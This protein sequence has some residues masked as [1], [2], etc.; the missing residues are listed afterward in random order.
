MMLDVTYSSQ[1]VSF[2]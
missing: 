2:H 1:R